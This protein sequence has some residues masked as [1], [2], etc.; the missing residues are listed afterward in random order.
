MAIERRAATVEIRVEGRKLSGVVM[1]Y[2]AV[3]PSH[4]ERFLPGSLRLAEAVHL[5]LHHDPERAVAWHPGGGLTLTNGREALTMRAELPPLP[6]A[7][8][9]L[10]EILGGQISGLSVEFNAVK[11]T[12]EGGL[13]VIQEAVLRGIGIVRSPSYKQSQVEARRR[14][15]RVN[16]HS[17]DDI[18]ICGR[19]T[20]DPPPWELRTLRSPPMRRLWRADQVRNAIWQSIPPSRRTSPIVFSSPLISSAYAGTGLGRR[21]SIKLKIFW[22]KLLGTA[23]S[24]N[25]NVTYRP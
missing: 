3:S 20:T 13:R 2:G 6:A 11:E 17:P 16:R 25:W 23:T 8:R 1:R 24:A 7:D 12:R 21:S 10:A 19:R 5:D 22:N 18:Q 14:R 4:R 15:D 9:A